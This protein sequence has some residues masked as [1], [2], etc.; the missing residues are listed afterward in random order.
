M[1]YLDEMHPWGW[2]S[3]LHTGFRVLLFLLP[4][5]LVVEPSAA[6]LAPYLPAFHHVLHRDDNR[7]NLCNY[8]QVPI[9]CFLLKMFP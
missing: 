4:V 2:A 6:F 5:D 9:K 7:L 3:K 1:T 8:R